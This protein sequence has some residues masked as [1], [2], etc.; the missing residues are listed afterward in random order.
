MQIAFGNK[1][2]EHQQGRVFSDQLVSVIVDEFID[3][4]RTIN[5]ESTLDWYWKPLKDFVGYVG[6]QCRVSK[7][8][9]SDVEKWVAKNWSTTSRGKPVSE[10]SLKHPLRAVKACFH[11]A[12]TKGNLIPENPFKL[13][14][15]GDYSGTEVIPTA[16]QFAQILSHWSHDKDFIDLL[17]FEALTGPELKRPAT[18]GLAK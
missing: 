11:W 12:S 14:E 3:Y 2:R 4:Q 7:L 18:S 13:I 16:D 15:I 8:S 9:V 10:N 1:L 6:P 5:K 17:Q